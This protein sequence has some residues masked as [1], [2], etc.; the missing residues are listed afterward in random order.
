MTSNSIFLFLVSSLLTV[1]GQ[2][3]QEDIQ[4]AQL[5]VMSGWQFQ[6]ANTTCAPYATST[7]LNIQDCQSACLSEV[8][9][10][11]FT[12][13]ETVAICEIFTNVQSQ[14]SYMFLAVDATTMVIMDRT[15]V[16]PEPTATITKSPSTSIPTVTSTISTTATTTANTCLSLFNTYRIYSAGSSP[17]SAVSNDFN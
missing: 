14:A 6:C 11:V 2:S 15:R 7:A 4:S 3:A 1:S 17:L 8:Q 5:T 10:E 13:R 9:C 12:F 16:P